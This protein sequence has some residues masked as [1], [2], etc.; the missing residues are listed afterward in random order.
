VSFQ[1]LVEDRPLATRVILVRHGETSFNLEGRVQGH[2]DV[3]TLTEKGL[4]EAVLVGKALEGISFQ[5]FYHSPL[6]RAQQTA[7]SIQTVLTEAGQSVPTPQV[8]RNLIEISLPEW[9]GQLFEDIKQSDPE[10]YQAWHKA[11]H[12]L[13]MVREDRPGE[14]FCPI[15]ALF[16][17]AKQ[18]WTELLPKH[19]NQTILLVAHSGINRSL[20]A[21]ALGISAERYTTLQ[22]AN[23]N[24]SVLNFTESTLGSAQL[25]SLNLTSHLGKPLPKPR[26]GYESVRLVLVRHGETDWNRQG[27]FQGQMDIPLN[28]NG[29]TQAQQAAEF[30]K[31]APFDFAITSPMQRPKETAEFILKHHPQIPLGQEPEFCE[32]SHGTWEGKLESEIESGYP[33]MLEQWRVQPET[34]QMPEGENL[35]QVWDRAI[36][37][38]DKLVHQ[39]RENN[40]HTGLVVAHDAI[41]KV[42]LCHVAGAGIEK[43]W[44]FK[45]GNG[46]VSIIDY[47]AE[48]APILQ[49]MNITTH[50]AGG[51][52]DRTAAGAL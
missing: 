49:S 44:S 11:P 27:R 1:S 16:E 25:E 28:D 29:R 12:T 39:A 3:S 23:C 45:Q 40:T 34:V 35:Q 47:P 17:Q 52:L 50:L 19:P 9:E 20:I 2:I 24:I 13:K 22:Q 46:A 18:F 42:I 36:A 48:G 31:A 6:R 14:E 7:E 41:N 51:I 8:D 21:T 43:F 37:A 15:L 33:G 32:I 5:A 10:R 38:W 4:A 30:L 26:K